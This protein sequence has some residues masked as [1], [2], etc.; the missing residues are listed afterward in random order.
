MSATL[1]SDEARHDAD[2]QQEARAAPHDRQ[3]DVANRRRLPTHDRAKTYLVAPDRPY[4]KSLAGERRRG[5][6]Q[7]QRCRASTGRSA[8]SSR[9]STRC[10]PK[11]DVSGKAPLSVVDI[12]SGK[13]YLTFALYDHL[14]T[15]ARPRLPRDRYRGARRSRRFLQRIGSRA[16]LFRPLASRPPKRTE[17]SAKS[18]DIVIALHACDTAT[19]DAMALR[20]RRRC[21]S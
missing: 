20:H 8:T 6:R 5:P 1:F 13:G 11:A 18:V 14:A 16:R 17:T 19:D 2:L 9:S 15:N 10:S 21:A 7:T 3:A 4:L 12:G